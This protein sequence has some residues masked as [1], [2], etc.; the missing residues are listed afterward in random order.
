[1]NCPPVRI[2]HI[3]G[4][5]NRGGTETWLVQ[6]LRHI[7]R[8]K[9]QFDFLVPDPGPYDFQAD[10]E[11]LGSTVIP[12]HFPEHALLFSRN[13]I[14]TLRK[15]GPYDCVHS[16]VHYFSALPL[17]LARVVGIPIRIVHSHTDQTLYDGES[18][19]L[20]R[21]YAWTMK[22]V[23]WLAATRGTAVSCRAADSLF[24]PGWRESDR[25]STMPLGI[26]LEP[27]VQYV[28]QLAV[29]RELGIPPSAFVV[30]HVGRFHYPKNH[31][32][33]V[34]IAQEL[35]KLA[36][37]V[38]FL[39]VGEGPLRAKIELKVSSL[40]L[41]RYF[42]FTGLRS[43]VARLMIGAMDAFLFPSHYEGLGLVVL[44]AQAA[45]LPCLVS[46][47]VPEEADAGLGLI[48][49][50][51]LREPPGDWARKLLS[52]CGSGARCKNSVASCSSLTSIESSSQHLVEL[53][54]NPGL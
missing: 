44:E 14:R 9:Y 31:S 33:L 7:D 48:L 4:S 41:S 8:H 35:I 12:C 23:I 20:R 19:I 1:M 53:Y 22:R 3:V 11:A 15:F 29:R 42:I 46:D 45:A 43:D 24:P 18:S 17:A 32:L 50:V 5:L 13:F 49:R 52:F 34:E 26:D 27:F 47:A 2:L 54:K 21:A 30:G 6:V 28:D 51:S 16:H 40:G 38:K 25:W 37:H 39:M 10:V 36:P